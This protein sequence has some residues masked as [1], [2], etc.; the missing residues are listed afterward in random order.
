MYNPF[1]CYKGNFNILPESATTGDLVIIHGDSYLYTGTSWDKVGTTIT[2]SP[3]KPV[4]R[5]IKITHCPDCN[6]P[7]ASGDVCPWCGV[8]YPLEEE[9]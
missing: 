7:R 9:F 8:P 3:I 4:R 6:A 1:F 2:T 5:I